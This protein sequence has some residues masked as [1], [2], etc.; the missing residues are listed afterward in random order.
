MASFEEAF[1]AEKLFRRLIFIGI[2]RAMVSVPSSINMTAKKFV[3]VI[4]ED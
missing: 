4:S 3:T 2:T 1:V